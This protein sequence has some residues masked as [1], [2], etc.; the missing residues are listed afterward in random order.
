MLAV[1][2]LS[3]YMIAGRGSSTAAS[4]GEPPSSPSTGHSDTTTTSTGNGNSKPPVVR[5]SRLGSLAAPVQDAAVT[6]LNDR[7][8]CFG[9]LDRNGA[10]AATVSSIAGDRVATAGVLPVA[11]HDAAAATLNGHL[12]VLGGGQA[13]SYPGIA[14]FDP[15]SGR[16]RLVAQLPTPLSDLAVATLGNTTYVVGG[17]TGSSWSDRIQALTG[18]RV[19]LAGRLPVALRYAAVAP[20]GSDVVIAGGRTLHGVSD[21]IYRFAPATGRVVKI[22]SLKQPVMHAGAGLLGGAMYVVGGI[23]PGGAPVDSVQA[24]TPAGES[25]VAARLPHA[26][27]DAGVATVSDRIVVVG[28]NDGSGPVS[29][30]LKIDLGQAA[31]SQP[32]VTPPTGPPAMFRGPLP[33]DLLIADRGNN[34]MMIVNPAHQII[35]RYPSKPGQRRLNFDDDAFFTPGGRSII[36]NEEDNH[37]IVQIAYPSG[38]LIWSYGHSGVPGSGRGYLNTPDDAY[39]LRNGMVI[40]AD[41]KNCRILEIRGRRVVR[42]IGGAGGCVHDPPRSFGSPNGDTPLPNGNILVSE[43]NGSWVD[44]I[45]LDGRL[46]R[47][48]HAPVSYPSDP[49]LT[50]NGNILLSDYASPGGVVI[51]DRQTGKLLWRYHALNTASVLDHPSLAAMLPNGLIIVVDDYN[52]RIVIIRPRTQRIVW[53]Y[54][55]TGVGGTAA[56]YLHIP[57]GFD[58]IPVT[59]AGKP[60]PAAIKHGR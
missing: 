26:L 50:R 49:Q 23:A 12:L 27:S 33:G 45:T 48:L 31:V 6:T 47:S 13:Q 16:T 3:V 24:I 1:A 54:G 19:K 46:V 55:H 2:G 35:W 52:D 8:Y 29:T 25:H 41:D 40:V 44:E 60:N 18:T 4:T 10:S 32:D 17:Y 30:V 21:A 14:S 20:M 7:V 15:R 36:S 39:K 42:S 28:G 58:F 11:V 53:Q 59:D 37:D 56:G 22:G 51:I 9:G 5:V 38:R 57:D 43:I 34:R